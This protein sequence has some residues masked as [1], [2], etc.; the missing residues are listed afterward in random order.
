MNIYIYIH[1]SF[2]WNWSKSALKDDALF[3]ASYVNNANS[4]EIEWPDSY[5]I[6]ELGYMLHVVKGV[7]KCG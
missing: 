5:I 1:K 3:I 7:M 6:E 4:H 2:L